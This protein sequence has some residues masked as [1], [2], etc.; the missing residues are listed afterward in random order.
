[1]QKVID[2]ESRM[3]HHAGMFVRNY[4]MKVD[5]QFSHY[6]VYED[7]ILGCLC[8]MLLESGIGD[9]ILPPKGIG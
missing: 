8:N 1:M 9:A 4:Q 3:E 5:W 2:K 6:M 7:G